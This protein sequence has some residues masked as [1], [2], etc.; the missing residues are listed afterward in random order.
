M[1]R[2]SRAITA[3]KM[4]ALCALLSASACNRSEASAESAPAEEGSA[5]ASSAS[6]PPAA[7]KAEWEACPGNIERAKS[8]PALAGAPAYEKERVHMARVRGA[9]LLWRRT[10]KPSPTLDE[11]AKHTG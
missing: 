1:V 9:A 10:P 11:L 3:M 4:A 6:P 7:G 8:E 2:A 5:A